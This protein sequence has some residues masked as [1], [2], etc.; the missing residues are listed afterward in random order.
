MR[1]T[2]LVS[3]SGLASVCTAQVRYEVTNLTDL[4]GLAASADITDMNSAGTIVGGQQGFGFAI[5]GGKYSVLERPKGAVDYFALAVNDN[6]VIL[7]PG[8]FA[9]GPDRSIIWV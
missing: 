8:S 9:G 6:G 4:Y 3:L 2:L 7:G 5:A 1:L